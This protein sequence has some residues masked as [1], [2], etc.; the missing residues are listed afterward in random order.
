MIYLD[1]VLQKKIL[2]TFHYALKR[3]RY[4]ILGKSESITNSAQLYAQ[5]DKK[6]KVFQ[7]KR[8]GFS[9]PS[10]DMTYRT[11]EVDKK[12]ILSNRK[13]PKNVSDHQLDLEQLVDNILLSK[14]IP[15]SVVVNNELEILQFRGS[16]GLYLEPSPGR[17]SLNLLK[18]AKTALSL[19]LR[20]AIH[21]AGKV[22]ETVRRQ[23]IPLLINEKNHLV[24]VEVVPLNRDGDE[25]LFL[26]IFEKMLLPEA[27][28]KGSNGNK[29]A[30]VLA[31]ENELSEVKEDLRSIIESQGA[32]NEE[33]QSANEEIVSSN[34]ELQSINEELETA[35][36]ELEST[37]EE[38]MTIN[39]E[40]QLRNEQLSQSYEYAELMFDT[41]SEGI[42][43]L[44]KE[45]RIKSANKAFLKIFKIKEA[46]LEGQP[47]FEVLNSQWSMPQMIELL[48]V[49]I[50]RYGEHQGMVITYD[51]EG[52]GMKKFVVNCKRMSGKLQ[53]EQ[54]TLLA[55]QD[56]TGNLEV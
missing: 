26:V 1:V 4:L 14:Y 6:Y 48:Q 56:I 40:L 30:A 18:M 43:V 12:N 29:E 8:E 27:G 46:L 5:P 3:D 32:T 31:L 37:N 16:T 25:G 23:G 11:P 45:F 36:E 9:K 7:K 24:Q 22:G 35:K 53:E 2:N 55:F 50:P 13:T 10:F 41:V 47:F 42:V 54:I 39:T 20:S 38:L 17:A 52:I 44:D 51:F 28:V 15:A 21:K 34:E 33:L 19:E 49:I